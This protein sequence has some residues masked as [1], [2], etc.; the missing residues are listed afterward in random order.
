[1][2]C[3]YGRRKTPASIFYCKLIKQ[4]WKGGYVDNQIGPDWKAFTQRITLAYDT[5]EILTP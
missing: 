3:K 1:M 2:N 4:P 5:T